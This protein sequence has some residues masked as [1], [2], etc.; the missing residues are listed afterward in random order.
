L[1]IT[2]L[3][4]CLEQDADNLPALDSLAVAL[5]ATNNHARAIEILGPV[6]AAMPD[7]AQLAYRLGIARYQ[8]GDLTGASRDLEDACRRDPAN[9][10]AKYF[11]AASLRGQGNWLESEKWYREALAHEPGSVPIQNDLASIL[12][13]LKR[14]DD[15]EKILRTALTMDPGSADV[16][17][18]LGRLLL[19]MGHRA[20]E[21]LA[22]HDKAIASRP[23]YAAAHNNR[24]AA[25]YVLN[26][27]KDAEASCRRAIELKPAFPDAYLNLGN[28]LLYRSDYDGAASSLRT[29]IA[30]RHGDF[31]EAQYMLGQ[32][33]LAQGKFEGAWPNFDA[34]WRCPS[35]GTAD[36]G[37]G[38]PR[39]T[40]IAPQDGPVYVWAEQGLGDEILY[41]SMVPDLLTRGMEVI[42][43]CSARL[44]PLWR[45]SYP[46]LNLVERGARSDNRQILDKAKCQ[47]PI[48]SLGAFVRGSAA[49]FPVQ[50]GFL[51][52]DQA[53]RNA[54]RK[55]MGTESKLT[56]GLSW[57]SANP[58]IGR[59]KSVPLEM[60]CAALPMDSVCPINLQYG[61]TEGERRALAGK[62]GIELVTL[63]DLNLQDDM[64]ALASAI[65]ACDVVISVS[66]VTAHLAGALG[67]PMWILVPMGSGRFWYWGAG[68][69]DTPW[70][71]TAHVFH[72]S[73]AGSWSRPLEQVAREMRDLIA[74]K[75]K[76]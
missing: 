55:S 56:V 57:L 52:S 27:L 67:V 62:S 32:V 2:H 37:L 21:A 33:L 48:G 29:A 9:G 35:P 75:A 28:V 50:T 4:K 6:R 54:F 8:S 10:R 11:L 19:T 16:H 53:R 70:Y 44:I 69:P 5:S 59:F 17:T 60:L 39:M 7:S 38:L 43:E 36:G 66:N 63:P 42:L 41:G 71:R 25:L 3:E 58:K 31:P 51:R 18:N 34:R 47:I 68:G 64:D 40:R 26:R 65:S 23:D 72:Q 12:I 61:D 22:H 24:G 20:N 46:N 49:D 14:F 30:Q 15:A 74:C 45:R 76:T 1:A 13:E 73:S